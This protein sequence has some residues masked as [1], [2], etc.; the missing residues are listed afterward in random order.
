ML[1]NNSVRNS[2]NTKAVSMAT[3]NWLIM[4]ILR[5][6]RNPYIHAVYKMSAAG[7]TCSYQCVL[8][9]FKWTIT[10][11]H[12][13]TCSSATRRKHS[14]SLSRRHVEA[15]W[16]LSRPAVSLVLSL[17]FTYSC[18]L[19]RS[20]KE[21]E[22]DKATGRGG[23]RAR[24]VECGLSCRSFQNQPI[25]CRV[26]HAN[27]LN[28]PKTLLHNSDCFYYSIDYETL[29]Y[30]LTGHNQMIKVNHCVEF[31]IIVIWFSLF[32]PPTQSSPP[33]TLLSS[34]S[35]SHSPFS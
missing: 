22:D 4:F 17:S 16:V 25:T 19:L 21:M 15:W 18:L 9:Y 31:W 30:C 6:I 7:G 10:S 8:R 11:L 24:D 28:I 29:I 20:P 35:L 26:A 33:S 34:S 27:I 23:R 5:I 1:F 32:S 3:M 14:L 13:V 12:R 2:K